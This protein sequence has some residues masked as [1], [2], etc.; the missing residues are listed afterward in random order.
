[1]TSTQDSPTTL[2]ERELRRLT[3]LADGT[4]PAW[5]RTRLQRWLAQAPERRAELERQRHAVSALRRIDVGAPASLRARVESAHAASSGQPRSRTSIVGRPAMAGGVAGVAVVIAAGLILLGGGQEPTIGE[6]DELATLSASGPAPEPRATEP[7][8]LAAAVEGV[9]FP[10]WG[11]DLGWRA[12]GRRVDELDG[13]QAE[14]VFYEHT[15][16]RVG[17]TIV[18]GEALEWPPDTEVVTREGIEFHSYRDGG[19]VVVTWLRRG[20]V[21][22]LS[23]RGAERDTLLDL[24]A[25]NGAGAVVS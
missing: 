15:G 7:A 22:V 24:A 21:C 8:L 5:R 17:Y 16:D 25:W 14:T 18:S 12:N 11:P 10:N 13:R 19:R 3:S 9:A 6:A 2:G 20:H 1:V 4:L 23:G